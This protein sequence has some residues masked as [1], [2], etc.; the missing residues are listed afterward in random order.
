[1]N[2]DEVPVATL[3][4]GPVSPAGYCSA[5][6][7]SKYQSRAGLIAGGFLLAQFVLPMVAMAIMMPFFMFNMFSLKLAQVDGGVYFD[8][9][10]WYTTRDDSPF[11]RGRD[12]DGPKL[13]SI[14]PFAEKVEAREVATLT[15]GSPRLLAG[16]ERLWVVGEGA[17]G[18]LE[19]DE[20]VKLTSDGALGDCCQPFL[21]QGKP[22][23]I[24]ELLSGVALR[25]YDQERR[26]WVQQA[27]VAS[28]AW[29][30]QFNSMDQLRVL[31]IAGELHCFLQRRGAVYY[32]QGSPLENADDLDSWKPACNP[33]YGRWSVMALEGK[34]AIVYHD[35]QQVF[36]KKL[37]AGQW[38][39]FCNLKATMVTDLGAYATGEGDEFV[40]MTQSFP[41][42][43]SVRV[44]KGGKVVS[45]RQYGRSFPFPPGF[46]LMLTLPHLVTVLLPLLLVFLLAP[47]MRK[48]RVGYLTVGERTVHYASVARR[49][50]AQI[51]DSLIASL[52]FMAGG[53]MFLGAFGDFESMFNPGWMIGVMLFWAVGM[54]W[55]L[56]CFFIYSAM[57]GKGG[58][59]PGKRIAGI[60]VVGADLEPCGFG[61]G[62]IRNLL[63]IVD[64][65]FQFMV[66][67]MVVAFTE[68]WQRVGDLAAKT[69]VIRAE[70]KT[71]R[72]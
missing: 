43:L 35:G 61:R 1:M 27:K 70:K 37:E 30:D 19:N 67:I 5:E 8:G 53:I 26:S 38:L 45:R 34:P 31:S 22:A 41:G 18:Y 50:V 6:D 47:Q 56:G 32:R 49:G 66:G 62:L 71:P 17:L 28:V 14:D 60:R 4:D 2:P 63:K 20:I 24:Q 54:V 13:Y 64:G 39:Q 10:V 68:K 40:L 52:P 15:M 48:Y 69:I 3:A 23:V 46:M 72:C 21:Y 29:A 12:G 55:S 33:E 16:S 25:V 44:V 11:A 57:E 58:Q 65:F 51:I 9:Q 42:S 36:G 7:K 59:T